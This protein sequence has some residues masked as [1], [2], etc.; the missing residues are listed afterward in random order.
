VY[1]FWLVIT[2]FT[3][4]QT[5]GQQDSI[6]TF[7]LQKE[8]HFAV[9][10][11]ITLEPNSIYPKAVELK[12][13]YSSEVVNSSLYK[14]NYEKAQLTFNP[15]FIN[16]YGSKD[17]VSIKYFIFPDYLTKT[18]QNYDSVKVFPNPKQRRPI[19][20]NLPKESIS[21]KPF[22][23]LNTEGNLIRGITVGNN[24]DAVLNS[25]L[26][27]TIEG[28]LSPKVSLKG[29][30][31]DTNIPIQENGYSQDAKDIDRIYMELVGPQWMISG[32]DVMM[33]NDDFYFMN[34]TKK[35]QGV[36]LDVNTKNVNAFTSGALVKGRFATHE[37]K[38][39]EANQGPYKII[40]E[41]GE[42]YIFLIQDSESVYI[43]GQIQKRGV[44]ADYV[45]DYSTG[46]ITFTTAR[47]INSQM[48][49]VVEYQYSDRQ[50]NRFV[51][52]NAAS[53]AA[54]KWGIATGFYAE[55]DM[56]NQPLEINLSTEQIAQLADANPDGAQIYIAQAIET[57]FDE[58]LIL[59]RKI[60]SGGSEVYEYSTDQNETLYQVS[61]TYFGEN[62]GDYTIQ[63]YLATGRIMQYVGENMG[64]YKAVIP[65]QAPNA[66]QIVGLKSFYKP[67]DKS[68]VE[69]E[70]SWEQISHNLFALNKGKTGYNP[71]IKTLWNQNWLDKKWKLNTN[72]Q[73]DYMDTNFQTLEG[74]YEVEF[75][76]NWNLE[77]PIGNLSFFKA[78]T[79]F[80]QSENKA[81]SYTFDNLQYS[82][83]Y[84]GNKHRLF[85]NWETKNWHFSHLSGLLNA[86]GDV[87]NTKFVS[88]NSTL[89]FQQKKWWAEGTFNFEKNAS[90]E[91][92][93]EIYSARSFGLKEQLFTAG[94]G[95]T[96]KVY[97]KFGWNRQQNDSL[98]NNALAKV[99][100]ANT[101][102]IESQLVE[103]ENTNLKAF[104]NYRVFNQVLGNDIKA[105]NTRIQYRQQLWHQLV[106]LQSEYHNASGQIAQQD[107]TYVETEPGQGYYAWIDYNEN[108]I[109]ELD[110]FEIA[111]FPDQARYLRFS[112]PNVNY[113]PTQEAKFSQNFVLN[114]SQWTQQTGLKKWLSHWYNRLSIS[115]QN[116]K[117]RIG[118]T[119]YLNPFDFNNEQVLGHQYQ[120]QNQLVFNRGLSHFTTS[121]TLGDSRRKLWQQWGSITQDLSVHTLNFQHLIEH[122]WEILLQALTSQNT[123][124]NE[125]FINRD[126]KLQTY[127]AQPAIKYYFTKKHWLSGGLAWI[128]K[129]NE[130]GDQESL[131]A[132]QI[133]VN[134][135]LAMKEQSRLDIQFK[136]INN[137]FTGNSFSAVG[138]QMLEGLQPGKNT[139]WHVLWTQKMNDF[140]Y[141]NLNYSG[142]SHTDSQTIHTG[143]VQLRAQF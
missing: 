56:K 32:G 91:E 120:L 55:S 128:D 45:I 116:S 122:Q 102:F 51:S 139:T 63:E 135:Q 22:E 36:T 94:I 123:S 14:L 98:R 87:E 7:G 121:Y 3:I 141:L 65:L 1:K 111:L 9:R 136:W 33:E 117:L 15:Q 18:Y 95:D 35:V 133:Q 118:N 30:L 131:S 96:A 75:N 129:Q 119:A 70:T 100:H 84:Q 138:Y 54:K 48:R 103:N 24:Q 39:K 16:Q 29:H 61:F 44:E 85:I 11:T 93:T 8:R 47:P 20:L 71:A 143:N 69:I 104:I 17:S 127:Q 142:R 12:L 106:S 34:F 2:F 125:S 113:L 92:N 86:K 31:N 41:T 38:G 101:Y 74:M 130:I 109:R 73:Y 59:Y 89:R 77:N 124:T 37:F 112:L 42:R 81:I 10:D 110:E 43:N 83:N 62:Q 68:K 23:G 60:D 52:M 58:N 13:L 134:Y 137:R 88:N 107:Y 78:E 50:Y 126:F 105:L 4:I 27:L 19:I 57:P 132:S 76:R 97:A 21:N 40:G 114:P 72:F 115:A 140:L 49:I 64:D 90:K 67:N 53:F 108:G 6:P 5:F 46:E 25:S 66:Q 99:N 82:Q 80:Y 28:K 79:R 26:D